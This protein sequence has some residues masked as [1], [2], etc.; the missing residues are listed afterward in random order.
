MNRVSFFDGRPRASQLKQWHLDMR[1][2]VDDLELKTLDLIAQ[3]APVPDAVL[4]MTP[5]EVA[6]YFEEARVSSTQPR[7]SST[8]FRVSVAKRR[9]L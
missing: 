8:I 4:G 3:H 9:T 5:G 7:A 1:S 6:R 2:A